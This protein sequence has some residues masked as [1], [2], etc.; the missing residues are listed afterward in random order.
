[1][2]GS[3]QD[4]TAAETLSKANTQLT[5][6]GLALTSFAQFNINVSEEDIEKIKQLS[7][8]KAFTQV[9]GSYSDYA[10]GQA[11]ID[12]AKGVEQGNVGAQPGMMVGMMMGANGPSGT[13]IVQPGPAASSAGGRFC[14]NCG[15]AIQTGAKFCANCGTAL[16]AE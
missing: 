6:F 3:I 1:L 11:M 13:P 5:S 16:P 4:Q 10:K 15:T 14:T 12:I 8:A 7:E 9:A 2:L